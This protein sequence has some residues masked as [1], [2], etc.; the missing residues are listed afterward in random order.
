M[1]T[2]LQLY[3]QIEEN[4]QVANQKVESYRSYIQQLV[5]VNQA[6]LQKLE[7]KEAEL[8]DCQEKNNLLTINQNKDIDTAEIKE[9]INQLVQE[10]DACITFIKSK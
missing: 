5:E 9:K 4:L 7:E 8:K 2:F 10:I 6:L 3:Q 1:T